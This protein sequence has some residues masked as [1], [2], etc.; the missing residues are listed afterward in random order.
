VTYVAAYARAVGWDEDSVA[1]ALERLPHR[2]PGSRLVIT[3][4]RIEMELAPGVRLVMRRFVC[5]DFDPTPGTLRCRAHIH[6]G[7]CCHPEHSVCM[8]WQ[9][10]NSR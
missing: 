3:E 6:Q 4:R 7:G 10:T 2:L 9:R 5:P 8:E 1:L